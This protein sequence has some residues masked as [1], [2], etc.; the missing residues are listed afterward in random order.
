MTS[1]HRP[2]TLAG[3][4]FPIPASVAE[5]RLRAVTL[6]VAGVAFLALL[7]QLRLQVGPV[8]VTG[9]TLGVLLLGAAYGLSLGLLTSGAYVALGAAGLPL[10]TGDVA[11]VAYLLG[12]TGGYLLGFVL[13][14]AL[15][16]ALA[17][18]GWDRSVWSTAAAML[19]ASAVIYACGLAWLHVA[20]GGSWG[21]TLRLGLLPFL[22]GD[23]IK[24][25]AATILLPTAWRLVGRRS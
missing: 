19:L 20:L 22:V 21:H 5:Q 8:P 11:G 14:A 12:P 18:R 24:L 1:A 6:V 10:F 4:L 25:A 3:R 2:S 17:E 9:Q 7:A 15:L 16:G 23:L 13:A